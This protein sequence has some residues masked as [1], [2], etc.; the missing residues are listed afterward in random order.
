MKMSTL[1]RIAVLRALQ[2]AWKIHAPHVAN[3]K[4]DKGCWVCAEGEYRIWPCAT[5]MA[6]MDALNWPHNK[7]ELLESAIEDRLN[8][9]VKSK[10]KKDKADHE[11]DAMPDPPQIVSVKEKLMGYM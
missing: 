7:P 8:C 6:I 3:S 2:A 5:A 11:M 9:L 4:G 1:D 10:A